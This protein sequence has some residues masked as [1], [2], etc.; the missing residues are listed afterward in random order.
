MKLELKKG[1]K[2]KIILGKKY[3]IFM[4]VPNYNNGGDTAI[5]VGSVNF[6]KIIGKFNF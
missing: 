6:L 3:A 5:Y 1:H 2:I 4:G